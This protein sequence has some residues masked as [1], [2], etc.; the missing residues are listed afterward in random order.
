REIAVAALVDRVRNRLA[1]NVEAPLEFFLALDARA[2]TDEHLHME[3][4]GRLH[5]FAE[6]SIVGRYFAP[7]EQR[8]LFGFHLLGDDALDD[9]AP[10][11]VTRHEQ[12]TDRVFAGLRQREAELLGLAREERM[13]DL[14]QD[15]GTVAEAR[16][17]ADGA[18][19]L[20]VAQDGQRIGNDLTRLLALDVGDKADTAG[21]LLERRVVKTFRRRSI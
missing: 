10:G 6:R 21:I 7:A 14:H 17:G 16:I 15:A 3:G 2:A 8:Q 19:V 4:F 18:A 20:E 1:Q 9:F 12:R 11:G 13:R 5:A